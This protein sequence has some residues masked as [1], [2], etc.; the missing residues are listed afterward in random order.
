MN[1]LELKVAV[2]L[3]SRKVVDWWYRSIVKPSGYFLCGWRKQRIYPDFIASIASGTA[4]ERLVIE[5]KGAHLLG[6]EDTEYKRK[7][8]EALTAA[9]QESQTLRLGALGL[10]VKTAKI[11]LTLLSENSWQADIAAHF[12]PAESTR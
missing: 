9:S 6:N 10:Q 8:F 3:D 11:S 4:M 7:V 1:D 2:E 12:G 5:T